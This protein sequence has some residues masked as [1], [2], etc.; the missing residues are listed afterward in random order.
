MANDWSMWLAPLAFI[1]LILP[2]LGAN[3]NFAAIAP[4][5]GMA[6]L[7]VG[8]IVGIVGLAKHFKVF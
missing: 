2:A 5:G 6:W 3:M 8:L 4:V 1:L 7:S